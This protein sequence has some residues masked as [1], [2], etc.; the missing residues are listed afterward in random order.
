MA[1]GANH[2]PTLCKAPHMLHNK[3]GGP[4]FILVNHFTP[5]IKLTTFLN[6]WEKILPLILE[7]QLTKHTTE[8]VRMI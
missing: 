4:T 5:K 6:E 7:G 2:L 3:H 8:G 1:F